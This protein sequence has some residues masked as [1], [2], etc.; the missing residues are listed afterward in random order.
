MMRRLVLTAAAIALA[1]CGTLKSTLTPGPAG[2]RVGLAAPSVPLAALDA[3]LVRLQRELERRVARRGWDVPLQL[4]R[5]PD[6]RLRLRLGADESFEAGTAQLRPAAL[7]LY[8]EVAAV[9]RGAGVVTH[10]LVH[11]DADEPDPATGLTARRAASVLNYLA[12]VDVPAMQLRAE[13]RGAR[14]PATV[15]PGAGAVN[16]RVELV[17]KPIVAG[18]E[19]EAWRPPAPAGCGACESDEAHESHGGH[20]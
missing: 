15:E 2:A 20:G 5:S 8:A 14:E 7:N 16:R 13:G 6:A 17:I 12:T 19:S 3:E 18:Q 11:G 4:S 1:G 10:V 9:L